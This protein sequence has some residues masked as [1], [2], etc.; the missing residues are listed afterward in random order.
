MKKAKNENVHVSAHVAPEIAKAAKIAAINEGVSL[1][2]WISQ[3]IIRQLAAD[4]GRTDKEP[5]PKDRQ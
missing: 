2:A 5:S 3:A 1:Q 4:T